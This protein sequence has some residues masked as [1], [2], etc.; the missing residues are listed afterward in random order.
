MR[1]ENLYTVSLLYI[2][3]FVESITA[4]LVERLCI[5]SLLLYNQGFAEM[6]AVFYC[7]VAKK[8]R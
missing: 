3:R 7:I 5:M 4:F 2:Q 1:K 8:I 6:I